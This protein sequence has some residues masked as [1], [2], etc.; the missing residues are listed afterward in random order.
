MRRHIEQKE[1]NLQAGED[2]EK[3]GG[4]ILK[5]FDSPLHPMV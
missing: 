3:V 5:L 1:N 4:G 2:Q